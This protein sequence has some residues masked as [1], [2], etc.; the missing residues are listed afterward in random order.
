MEILNKIKLFVLVAGL[1]LVN[2]YVLKA[3]DYKKLQDAFVA[4]YSF[5]NNKE[6]QKA[7]EALKK[8]YDGESYELNV[9]LGWLYYY[10][11]NYPESISFYTKAIHLKPYSIEARFG[12]ALPASAMGNW[13]NV[14][15]QYFEILKI[16]AGNYTANYRVGLI[17][18][19]RKDY[20]LAY[21]YFEKIANMYPFDYDATHMYAWANYRM[22]K[23]REA[24][25]LFYKTLLIKPGDSSALEGLSL[26]K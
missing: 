5:E 2:T 15:N 11:G 20:A 13:N 22:G 7:I 21:K 10:A 23:V 4:S 25:V 16:D 6:Y 3:Q 18:Y 19:N 8:V 26:I 12:Y 17:Y 14:L 9:R 24:K 1:L